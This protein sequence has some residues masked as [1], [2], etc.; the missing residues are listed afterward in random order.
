MCNEE[1]K[2][3]PHSEVIKAWADGAVIQYLSK[4][5]DMWTDTPGNKPVWDAG[6]AYRVKPETFK[7]E[8]FVRW[9]W[10]KHT[11][12][13]R[14]ESEYGFKGMKSRQEVVERWSAFGGWLS[15][16]E[17]HTFDVEVK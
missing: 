2:P 13:P 1:R 4:M 15:D 17:R 14:P 9:W 6:C 8:A 3:R 16:W 12:L 10:D 5:G 11:K 7:A